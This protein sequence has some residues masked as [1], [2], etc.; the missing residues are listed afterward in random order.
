HYPAIDVEKSISRVM[1]AVVTQEHLVMARTIRQCLAQYTQNRELVSIGAYQRG[2]D[3]RVDQAIMIK[4]HIDNYTQQEMKEVIP[5]SRSLDE[6]RNLSM[7]LINDA[8]NRV[9]RMQPQ[10]LA[11]PQQNQAVASVSF[12]AQR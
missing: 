1:P 9:N 6:L 3:P 2:S 7:I 11:A 10:Q 8:Q 5:Y 4:P 12:N